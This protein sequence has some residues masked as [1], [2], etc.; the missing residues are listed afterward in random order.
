MS[1]YLVTIFILVAIAALAG[2]GL[3]MQWGQCGMINFGLAGFY[4]LAAY[5]CA[6]L[7]TNGVG[8]MLSLGIAVLVCALAS[9]LV[10]LISIRL[11]EDYLAIVTLGFAEC[12]RLAVLHENWLTEGALGIPGIP[13]PFADL[14]GARYYDVFF[15]GLCLLLL[16]TV[17]FVFAALTRSPFGR[18]M[19]AVREDPMV[20]AT[21]GKNVLS[22]RVRAFA[23]GGAAVGMAGGLHAFYFTY[24]DP[25]QFGPIITAYA[26]MAVIA[27]GRGSHAGLLIGAFSVIALLEGSRFL[28][29]VIPVLDAGQLAAVRLILIGLGLILLLIYLPQG[30]RREFRLHVRPESAAPD[31]AP[32]SR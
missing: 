18:L 19:R 3:N 11:S 30:I 9:A 21:L 27:G 7:A 5:T 15:L 1:A 25:A 29:D 12:L 31:A 4:M 13:R 23:V 6:L 16:A 24:I 10:S 20:A 2:L 8:P 28:K 32:G 17:Y 22:V 14:V 26:F